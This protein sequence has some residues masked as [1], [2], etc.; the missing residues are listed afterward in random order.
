[1]KNKTLNALEKLNQLKRLGML[2]KQQALAEMQTKL[3][4]LNRKIKDIAQTRSQEI[5]CS[6]DDNQSRL[7]LQTYLDGLRMQENALKKQLYDLADFMIPVQESVRESFRE[8]K[9]LEIAA[10]NLHT[11]LQQELDKKEQAFLDEISL[12]RKNGNKDD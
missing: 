6:R 8:V 11:R 7:T 5:E 4:V 1:M 10:E 3:Q 12:M 2:E 9:S